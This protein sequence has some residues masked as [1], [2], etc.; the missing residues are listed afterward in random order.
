MAVTRRTCAPLDAIPIA[1]EKTG[2]LL[3][4]AVSEAFRV[5]GWTVINNRYYADDIDGRARELDLIAY[6]VHRGDDLDIYTGA[7]VSCKKDATHT[8][9]FL[10]KARP[11]LDPNI[12]WEPVHYWT[13]CEPLSS[14]L[15]ND[16]WKKSYLNSDR[17]VRQDFFEATRSV[18]A[19]QLISPDGTA[20]RND[21]PIFDSISTLLKGLDYE[22][23]ALP[24]RAK[25][26]KRIYVFTLMT[27][28]DAPMVDVQYDATE[29]K[30][31]EIESLRHVARYLVRKRELSASIQFVS[32]DRTAAL[33]RSMAELAEYNKEQFVAL[34]KE[35]Y[36]AI[37]T[38]SD[39]RNYFAKAIEPRL[40][41]RMNDAL[42]QAGFSEKVT[43]LGFSY[44]NDRLHLDVDVTD[45]AAKSL[46]SNEKL[47]AQVQKTLHEVARYTG[48]FEIT[49]DFP[50]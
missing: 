43:S 21:A 18:F 39:V 31:Q 36:E 9:A 7:L 40:L 16:K 44:I 17:T 27:I 25:G 29:A 41:W 26:K 19:F 22:L 2:F 1:L 37:R 20:P 8:W 14:Y 50:F 28:V 30:A 32:S 6:R 23:G 10:S 47:R 3:E 12:D 48:S 15:K 35:S 38:N 13:D 45:E 4:H 24:S 42:R 49:W 34:S 33:V 46:D 5:A 11:N